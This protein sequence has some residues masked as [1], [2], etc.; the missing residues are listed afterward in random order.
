MWS[1]Y[2]HGN[3]HMKTTIKPSCPAQVRCLP[4]ALSIPL[5]RWVQAVCPRC[6]GLLRWLHWGRRKEGRW[7]PPHHLRSLEWKAHEEISV[8][9]LR[10]ESKRT[11][12]FHC[13]VALGKLTTRR[14]MEGSYSAL[15]SR[16]A[17]FTCRFTCIWASEF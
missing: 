5:R 15:R 11:V 1:P 2:S 12:I 14:G 9:L 16:C 8:V 6:L 7:E 10:N 3:F 13:Q 4:L 17:A